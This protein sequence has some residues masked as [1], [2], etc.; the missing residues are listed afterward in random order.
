MA[1]HQP[2]PGQAALH[3][4]GHHFAGDLVGEALLHREDTDLRSAGG[5]SFAS[6]SQRRGGTS[7]A[8]N[9]KNAVQN[10]DGKNYRLVSC[11]F[12]VPKPSKTH[13]CFLLKKVF[14]LWISARAPLDVFAGPP[15]PR[16]KCGT[17]HLDFGP[18]IPSLEFVC[19]WEPGLFGTDAS[20]Q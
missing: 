2:D 10:N 14:Y 4:N 17:R 3:P 11:G 20:D 7:E 16:W 15:P 13:L 12:G 19:L 18:M 9:K 8:N 1:S 6:G 5:A